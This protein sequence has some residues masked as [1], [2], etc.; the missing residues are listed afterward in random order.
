[1]V[2]TEKLRGRIVEENKTIQKLAPI[3]GYSAYTLGK[4]IANKTPMT[5]E[6]SKT[7][8]EELNIKKG[9]ISDFFYK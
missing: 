3:C 1:M 5:L 7:L 6:V 9:E 4:M 2:N 8:A